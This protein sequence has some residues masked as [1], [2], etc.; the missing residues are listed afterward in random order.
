MEAPDRTLWPPN[1]MPQFI[2]RETSLRG[3]VRPPRCSVSLWRALTSV[4]EE[5]LQLAAGGRDDG[6][7]EGFVS[8]YAKTLLQEKKKKKVFYFFLACH[9]WE[10][11]RFLMRYTRR[12]EAA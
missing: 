8:A 2:T 10:E 12:M 9:S 3:A 7:R 4:R 5:M 1:L 11:L 6:R